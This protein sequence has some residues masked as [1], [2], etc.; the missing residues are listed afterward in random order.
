MKP[1]SFITFVLLLCGPLLWAQ[2]FVVYVSDAANF[3]SG[4]FKIVKFDTK[5]SNVEVFI[6]ENLAWPQDIVFLEGTGTVLISN[7]NSGTIARYQ[8]QTGE[9]ID[10]F[11]TGIGGPTRMEIGPDDLLY[12]LEWE[13]NGKV[14]RYA[15][16]GTFVDEFTT[17]GVTQGIGMDWDAGGNLYVSSYGGAFVRKFDPN[18]NDLG[19]LIDSDL[20]GPTNL[21]ID[22]T[23]MLVLDWNAGNVQRFDVA[24]GAFLGTFIT[25][26]TNP[27]GID[28]LPNGNFLIGDNGT[29]SVL[30]F[31]SNGA[32]LGEYTQGGDLITPN[33][34]VLRDAT[35]GISETGRTAPFLFPTVGDRFSLRGDAAHSLDAIQVFSATGQLVTTWRPAS[36]TF[37]D[38]RALAE[39]LYLVTATLKG[40]QARQ[41][42]LV[43]H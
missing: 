27:E 21:M 8:S 29:N 11:A 37:W 39:G 18:G 28:R 40:K 30:E 6:D 34:V 22:G 2:D 35:L 9:Y 14:L 1:Y 42:I 13:P 38:A 15:L 26:L 10:D 5:G 12:V 36:E 24:T 43:K 17:V 31:D 41:K 32:P 20:S 16:D 3:S 33:A 23:A 25:G 7:L 19:I 4:P